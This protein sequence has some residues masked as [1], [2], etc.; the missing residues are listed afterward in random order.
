MLAGERAI[1]VLDNY[2]VV[3]GLDANTSRC[4]EGAKIGRSARLM[5]KQM[6]SKNVNSVRCVFHPC[7][8]CLVS[9][10]LPRSL[11]N[12]AI[13]GWIGSE[14]MFLESISPELAHSLTP[15]GEQKDKQPS[16]LARP[17][18]MTYTHT[19]DTLAITE[20]AKGSKEMPASLIDLCLSSVTHHLEKYTSIVLPNEL[21]LRLLSLLIRGKR[22]N[23]N[24]LLPFL[25]SN[26]RT[27]DLR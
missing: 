20:H 26:L 10:Q 4:G 18:L 21:T 19:S 8:T 3:C 22:L 15:Q 2:N 16:V 25:H 24:T 17:S 1:D 23:D 6:S 27:L 12:S 9:Q 5:R 14:L 13:G 7:L 11:R